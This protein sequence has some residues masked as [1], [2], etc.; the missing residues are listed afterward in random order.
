[1]WGKEYLTIFI[2]LVTEVLGFSLILPF[3]PFFAQD[4][5]ASPIMIGLLFAVFPFFQLF[6]A[7]IMGKLSDHYGR[8][9]LLII[10]QLA[11]GISF[12]VLGFSAALWMIFL[13]R[14]IDGLLGSNFT[15]AQAY[16][17]DIS[18]KKDRSIAFGV[19]GAAFGVGFLIGPG[20]GGWL[21][22][23]SYSL[24][25]FLAASMSLVSIAMIVWFLPE[26]V[27][28]KQG[29]IKLDGIRLSEFSKYFRR[30]KLSAS[31]WTFFT[32]ILAHA[33]FVS[34]LALYAERQLGLGPANVGLAL[35]YV[36]LISI[37]IRGGLLPRMV[38]SF[39]EKRLQY[40]GVLAILAG[41]GI[42]AF[43]GQ[44]QV[45]LVGMTL[46]AFGSGVSRPVMMGDISRRVSEKEQGAI[47]GVANSLG[48][49]TG[50]IGPLMGGF[51][52]NYFFP[53]SVML[54]G[55]VVMLFGLGMML[56]NEEK[57]LREIILGR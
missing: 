12:L 16:L 31:L 24:P 11:T 25:S 52:I 2:I 36:G 39:G 10:S 22:Q 1:M 50:I 40:I 43:A 19:S 47:M 17:S 8:K 6:S 45:F 51:L 7:P 5:G 54:A 32:F 4:L 56:R 14:I 9:P 21:A 20:I 44:W 38:K 55:A 28:R 33:I 46:F 3:L 34:M 27:K 13:S 41:L 23:Y 18:T 49:F 42:S 15:I 26:T 29:R 57:H 48:S 53:G 35:T 37:V 30:E